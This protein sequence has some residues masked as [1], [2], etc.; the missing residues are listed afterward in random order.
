MPMV[1]ISGLLVFWLRSIKLNYRDIDKHFV[2]VA[3][4]IRDLI[5][6][7]QLLQSNM[8]KK[9][10]IFNKKR[11]R[12]LRQEIPTSETTAGLIILAVLLIIVIWVVLQKDAYNPSD[13]DVSPKAV[14]KGSTNIAIYTHPLKRWNEQGSGDS[15]AAPALGIFPV[16]ILA[17]NW[18]V[19]SRLKQF[20]RN[21]LFEIINGEADKFLKQGF[22]ALFYIVLE[23]AATSEQIDIELFDQGD[24]RGSMG[25][26]SEYMSADTRIV[27][28]GDTAFLMTSSGAIG[29]KGRYFFRIIGT[30]ESSAIREKSKQLVD[31]LKSLPEEK[32]E[33]ATGY[34]ILNTVM[35]IDPAY[36]IFQGK[37]VFK[38]D[39]AREFWFGTP[40]PAENMR[41]FIHEA[42]SPEKSR[43][44]FER[45]IEEQG[46][47]FDIKE[48]KK[49]MA[50]LWHGYLKNW[51]AVGQSGIFIFGVEN[52]SDREAAIAS[53]TRLRRGVDSEK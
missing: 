37:D 8:A 9:E 20:D 12:V 36:I 30:A 22:I 51:F 49:E 44:L 31:A 53:L 42:S 43:A 23:S 35:G 15:A 38:F 18:T 47:D 11:R 1:Q 45:L 10:T 27:Q 25:V 2:Y 3:N 24:Q 19:S 39:F 5:I 48:Q 52:G 33:A 40:D 46:Y 28:D 4:P 13:R 34:L 26:F 7:F 41:Y 50:L 17:N 6:P 14:S 32:A 29:R 16:S 21:N